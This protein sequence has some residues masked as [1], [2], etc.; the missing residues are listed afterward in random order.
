MYGF[1]DR[2]RRM[3]GRALAPLFAPFDVD[4]AHVGRSRDLFRADQ[5]VRCGSDMHEKAIQS[6]SSSQSGQVY[7]R[8]RG[9]EVFYEKVHWEE[10][11]RV[12][13]VARLGRCRARSQTATLLN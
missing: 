4:N 3:K 11:S 2:F 6:S 7:A 8:K 10:R 1:R 12:N 13:A 5:G 9:T